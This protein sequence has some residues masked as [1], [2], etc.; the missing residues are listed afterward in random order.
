MKLRYKLPPNGETTK[1]AEYLLGNQGSQRAISRTSVQELLPAYSITLAGAL[2]SPDQMLS[3]TQQDEV[4][5]ARRLVAAPDFW[6]RFF[7]MLAQEDMPTNSTSVHKSHPPPGAWSFPAFRESKRK[8]P[9]MLGGGFLEGLIWLHYVSYLV[10]TRNPEIRIPSQG[11]GPEQ[12]TKNRQKREPAQR[13]AEVST[14]ALDSACIYIYIL[15]YVYT[16]VYICIHI[17]VHI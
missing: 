5:R 13:K 12:E 8:V 9:K 4:C 17:T 15:T 11:A 3:I 14:V 1:A 16:Y 10:L 7:G 6:T 2:R